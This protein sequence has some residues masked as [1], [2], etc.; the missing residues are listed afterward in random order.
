MKNKNTN[1]DISMSYR[2]MSYSKI[3]APAKKKSGVKSQIIKSNNDLRCK[4]G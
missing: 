2:N 3:D 1:G 4:K